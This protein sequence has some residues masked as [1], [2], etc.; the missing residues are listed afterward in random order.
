ML[1]VSALLSASCRLTLPL[2]LILTAVSGV[3]SVA[4]QEIDPRDYIGEDI[5]KYP[6][7]LRNK[8]EQ[9]FLRETGERFTGSQYDPR[10]PNYA[11]DKNTAK[12][13]R[14]SVADLDRS[15]MP[16]L[17]IRE[18]ISKGSMA[19]MRS[20]PELRS[21]FDYTVLDEK[22]IKSVAGRFQLEEK[23]KKE[24]PYTE[25]ELKYKEKL[26]DQKRVELELKKVTAELEGY[27]SL[28]ASELAKAALARL[29]ASDPDFI[30]K[31]S[32]IQTKYQQEFKSNLEIKNLVKALLEKRAKVH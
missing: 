3:H 10:C 4:G 31:L 1:S 11:F 30:I 8:I 28:K 16:S 22:D 5:S 25:E 29:D 18:E 14:E 21:S 26:L 12:C 9:A 27:N 24:N 20:R 17:D 7:Q 15:R 19:L 32:D 23:R 6:P 2:I 13:Y